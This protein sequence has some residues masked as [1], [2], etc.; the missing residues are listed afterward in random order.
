MATSR[1]I[2]TY[3]SL[4]PSPAVTSLH[5][6]TFRRQLD[7]LAATRTPVLPLTEIISAS[8]GVALTFDDG[9]SNLL[10]HA[11]PALARHR[12]PATFFINCDSASQGG[13]FLDWS[14]LR[15]ARSAGVDIGVHG[16][17]LLDLSRTPLPEAILQLDA[18]RREIEDRL[19]SP[20]LTCAYPYG[21]STPQLRNWARRAFQVSCGTRLRY[22][23]PHDD[24]ADLPRLDTYYL[25]SAPLFERLFQS[26]GRLYL[27]LRALL[28]EARARWS[29]TS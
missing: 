28:R 7:W 10:T 5:P 20:A 18:C 12:F 14:A 17:T 16:L 6:D 15:A 19:G 8:R 21:R 1:A 23:S 11:I 29:P 26:S 2:L 4:D 3:H 24:P 13:N 9:Y 22:L 27:G 25:Q